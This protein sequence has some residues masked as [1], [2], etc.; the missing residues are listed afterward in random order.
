MFID[1]IWKQCPLGGQAKHIGV[2]NKVQQFSL[3]KMLFLLIFIN[4]RDTSTLKEMWWSCDEHYNLYIFNFHIETV[5][6]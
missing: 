3:Q 5:Q 6:Y 1:T 4:Y 2:N